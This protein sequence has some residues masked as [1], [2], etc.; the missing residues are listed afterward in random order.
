[1][2]M[3]LNPLSFPHSF[4]D[5]CR[6]LSLTPLSYLWQRNQT[7]L[8]SEMISSGLN[9]IL[10]KIAGAGLT[11]SD[12]A[13][14]LSSMQPKLVSLHQRFGT[15]PCGEGGEYETFT[16]DSPL[17][18]HYIDIREKEVVVVDQ[19]DVAPVAYLRIKHALLAKK[20]ATT[21][22]GPGVPVPPLL[23][24]SFETLR[25]NLERS[26]CDAESDSTSGINS[27]LS[28]DLEP[29]VRRIGPWIAVGNIHLPTSHS[30]PLGVGEE[31]TSCFEILQSEYRLVIVTLLPIFSIRLV[32]AKL[33]PASRTSGTS[34][35]FS[36]PYAHASRPRR[37]DVHFC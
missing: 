28:P 23:E 9:A 21:S 32:D 15:H 26:V 13:K 36:D 31:I 19:N 22:V 37:A 35:N 16:I 29:S 25:Q 11:P 4:F 5:S 33:I 20:E 17:F 34:S 8:L 24:H 10:I 1:M 18:R 12:L 27:R 2:C 6:R 14:P 7:S 3:R 30:R